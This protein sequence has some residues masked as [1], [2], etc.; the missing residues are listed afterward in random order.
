MTRGDGPIGRI[1]CGHDA[2]D[3]DPS[4]GID[5]TRPYSRH[6]GGMITLRLIG[7]RLG[8]G[9]DRAIEL[10]TAAQ[11]TTDLRRNTGT[12]VGAGERPAA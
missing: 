9:S 12:G 7:I 6:E 8:E 1:A 5:T 10:V 2:G 11:I 4:L 3:L